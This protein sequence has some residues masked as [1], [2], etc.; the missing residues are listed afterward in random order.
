MLRLLLTLCVAGLLTSNGAAQVTYPARPETFDLQLRYRIRAD[1][2]ERIR[3]LRDLQRHLK[4]LGFVET[5]REDADLDLFDPAA[6]DFRGTLPAANLDRLFENR[7]VQTAV[8]VPA[9]QALPA[10]GKT[11]VGVR[12]RIASGFG[13]DEQRNLHEQVVR[14]LGLLGFRESLSYDHAG[15]SLVRGTL[16]GENVPK[17]TKDLRTL[18]SG[19]FLPAVPLDA[20]PAPLRTTLPIRTVEVLADQPAAAA[21]VAPQ[22]A[23]PAASP[24]LTPDARAFV[25]DPANAAKPQRF[26]L[27]LDDAPGDGWP[28]LRER[29]RTAVE[30]VS[31]EGLVGAVATVRVAR[32][33]DVAKLADAL[34]VRAVRLP[35]RGSLTG[36]VTAG[37]EKATTVA[38]LLKRSGVERLHQRGYR[39]A[40]QTVVLVATD[41]A[42]LLAAGRSLPA[43]VEFLDLTAELSPDLVA[44]PA[45]DGVGAG[46]LAAQV[47]HAA[48]P[49]ARLALV[50]IDSAA[51]HQL[52]GLARV[53]SGDIATGEAMQTRAFE[54]S[55][56]SDALTARRSAVLSEYAKAFADLGDEERTVNRRDA[57][58]K[59]LDALTEDEV[60]FRG[61]VGRFTRLKS[62]LD[63]LRGAAVVINTLVWETGYPQDGLNA[64]SRLIDAKFTPAPRQSGLRT[65]KATPAPVWVQA[66]GVDAAQVWS[67]PFLDA[68]GNGVLEFAA[69]ATAV[70]KGRWTRELNFLDFKSPDG[71]ATDVLP[72][73][74]KL[75]F[76]IQWREPQ[77]PGG[78]LLREPILPLT[79][80]L[81][82]QLDPAGKAAASDDLEQVAQSVG[83][84]VKLLR[85]AAS[86]AFEQTLEVTLPVAGVYALRVDGR[87]ATD[88]QIAALRQRVEVSPRVVIERVGPD[89]DK[90][91][92]S[93]RTFPAGRSGVGS[94]G[95][96]LTALT[97]G[98]SDGRTQLGTG[99]GVTLGAK[100]DLVAPGGVAVGTSTLTG[101]TASAAFVGGSAASLASAGVRATDLIRHFGVTPGGEFVLPD[102][103]LRSLTASR[104]ER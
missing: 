47:A 95:D 25:D 81:V 46:T 39:G 99:P 104:R 72:A 71:S 2:D 11:P 59:A 102:E 100:P 83:E 17:L 94:P 12:V 6:E 80:R 51:F 55:R 4:A 38:E 103:W 79:L 57:A 14:H 30:G 20:Q 18:P 9:G 61:V 10:D 53:V 24:K 1:R 86:G 54:L 15:Y 62:Q 91:T 66:A 93:F 68:D 7:A 77:D 50:R 60:A 52:Y 67:G 65:L 75:R 98:T 37:G 96:S 33:T 26:D 64:L 89:A 41:F 58:R 28:A 45:A 78:Y 73:G 21:E 56:R 42:G 70:P 22:P 36:R 44:D 16:P 63:G 87:P 31:V 84:P 27:V 92:P 69:E 88:P 19:W 49:D 74:L 90:G 29:L 85:T 101:S 40:G 48:A 35:R 97:V 43:N 8:A 32:A 3:Q 76:T 13:R 5:A 23:A 34:E 82:R